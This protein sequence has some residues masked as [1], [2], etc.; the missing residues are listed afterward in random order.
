[1]E[2]LEAWSDWDTRPGSPSKTRAG[3][4]MGRPCMTA[5]GLTP[6]MGLNCS[7]CSA[8][9]CS[10]MDVLGMDPGWALTQNHF[11]ESTSSQD[12]PAANQSSQAEFCQ[13]LGVVW[14]SEAGGCSSLH[15]ILVRKAP[16][17]HTLMGGQALLWLFSRGT[18]GPPS[19]EKETQPPQLAYVRTN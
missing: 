4:A 12:A 16:R 14:I 11:H 17:P 7:S 18:R 5:T 19:G 6:N 2:E 10:V 1:M 8:N 13:C 15:Q 3:S 9:T